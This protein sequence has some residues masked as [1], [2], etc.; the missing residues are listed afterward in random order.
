MII[1][2]ILIILNSMNNPKGR[3]GDGAHCCTVESIVTVDERG[4][5]VLP[6]NIRERA[7]IGPGDKLAIVTWER[8]GLACCMTLI[9]AEQ[10]GDMVQGMLGPIFN[11]EAAQTEDEKGNS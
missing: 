1:L 11:A 4:Q 8:E 7:N 2:I 9:K 10:L 6:K 5:M 3:C